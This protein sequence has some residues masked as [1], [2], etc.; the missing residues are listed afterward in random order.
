MTDLCRP[1]SGWTRHWKGER[2]GAWVYK[3]PDVPH[4]IIWSPRG[5]FYQD[6]RFGSVEA[7]Q[8][9]AMTKA[10]GCNDE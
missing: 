7:A 2:N 3:H 1:M 6:K 5:V 8:Q 4:V 10:K 9:H